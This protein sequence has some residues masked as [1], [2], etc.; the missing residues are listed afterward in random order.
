METITYTF[1]EVFHCNMCGKETGN[2]KVLGQRLNK[3][4]GLKPKTKTGLSVSVVKCNNCE[5]IYPNPFP[6]PL[7]IQDHYG[8]PPEDYWQETYFSVDAG[9]FSSQKK[10]QNLARR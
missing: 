10:S 7:N 1:R 6:I 8:V 2:N 4:Q 9:Y 3:S 5:L